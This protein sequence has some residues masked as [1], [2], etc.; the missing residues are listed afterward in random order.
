MGTAS[1]RARIGSRRP[2]TRGSRLRTL[3]IAA[4][5]ALGSSQPHGWARSA[6][7][8]DVASG[9]AISEVRQ[10]L[11]AGVVG[12]AQPAPPLADPAMVARWEAGEWSYRITAG[13]RQG[14][15]EREVL[16]PI[17]ATARKETWERTVGR[18]YT[19]YLRR[20]PEGSLVMPAEIAH[21]YKA[22]V[23]FE[24]PLS[25]LIAGLAPGDTHRF[26]GQI[27]VYSSR[28]PATKW[29]TGRIQATTT[30]AG[31]YRVATPAGTH[32]ARLIR[33]QY[34]IDILTVVSV[35]DTLYTFYADGVGK[36]AEAERRRISM[37]GLFG[38]DTTLGKVLMSFI[39]AR[40]P[41]SIEAP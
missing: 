15:T 17:S 38:S 5:I 32:N 9:I 22:L 24:P 27:D 36:V 41:E 19:L 8:Q 12:D 18:E 21:D 30:Y 34:R 6:D 28:D 39:P 40:R 33:T 1:W 23:H 29:Y 11:G 16:A 35:R 25:Y 20:A 31:V 3:W 26:D 7:T 13:A 4:L 37:V 2:R 14:Q 10:I